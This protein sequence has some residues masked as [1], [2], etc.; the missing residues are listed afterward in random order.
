MAP[1]F[2]WLAEMALNIRLLMGRPPFATVSTEGSS[3]FPAR[4][5]ESARGRLLR[6]LERLAVVLQ[7][8][9]QMA[10][11]AGKLDHHAALGARLAIFRARL[12]A[13]QSGPLLALALNKFAQEYATFI[14]VDLG[15]RGNS[16]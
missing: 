1:C 9:A 12:Q 7:L 10:Q 11:S 6:L 2:A 4:I 5:P 14:R 15:C 8:T 13:G 3:T 16:P